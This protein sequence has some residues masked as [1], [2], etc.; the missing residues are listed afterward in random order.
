MRRG[1]ACRGARLG[2]LSRRSSVS[3]R[4]WE[5]L[6]AHNRQQGPVREIMRAAVSSRLE[7]L[8]GELLAELA[9]TPKPDAGYGT[10]ARPQSTPRQRLQTAGEQRASTLTRGTAAS[11]PRRMDTAQQNPGRTQPASRTQSC[12]P[13]PC[14]RGASGSAQQTPRAQQTPPHR[15]MLCGTV[16][17]TNWCRARKEALRRLGLR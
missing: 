10:S 11:T 16:H 1:A 15:L 13:S 6:G 2:C 3:K 4:L 8:E 7:E 12:A 17:G 14:Q 5:T 9:A